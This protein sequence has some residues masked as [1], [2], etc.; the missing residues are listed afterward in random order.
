VNRV[1]ETSAG[2]KLAAFALIALGVTLR[3]ARLDLMEFKGDEQA[4]LNL[5]LQ[6]LNDRPWSTFVVPRH[7]MLSSQHIANAP[8]FN[9]LMALFWA[10]TEHP[11]GATAL[12]ALSNGIALYPLWKWAERRCGRERALVFLGIT[13]VS[14][15]FVLFSRK[16]WAQDLLLPGLVCLFWAIERY[17]ERRLWQAVILLGIASLIVGQLHQSGPIALAVLP[18]AA[19]TQ[20]FFGRENRSGALKAVRPSRVEISLLIVVIALNAFF[21]LPYFSYL[22]SL[23][24]EAF[25]GRPVAATYEPALL[26]RVMKQVVPAD[27]FYAFGPDRD[28]F[29]ADPL[30]RVVYYLAVGFGAP[31]AAYGVWRWLRSPLRIPVLGVWWWLVIAAF[32]VARIPTYPFYVLVLSPLPAVLAAGAFDGQ[33][34]W[35]WIERTVQLWRWTYVAALCALTISTGLWL[36]A[37]GGSRGDYGVIYAVREAQAHAILDGRLPANGRARHVIEDE[38]RP[39]DCHPVPVEVRWIGKWLNPKAVLIDRSTLCD[40]WIQRRDGLVYRWSV[41]SP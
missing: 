27:L 13:A 25:T 10:L 18:V 14:P 17:R 8:L 16:L 29:L 3:V 2:Q 31:L 30:R 28:D 11:V 4:A 20:L 38:H 26:A 35:P 22:T 24:V 33:F 9:W 5:G 1:Q 12:V 40:A 41:P 34:R 23:R 32:T 36:A 7:G 19:L 6:L 37:R 15:F 21:W 39:L